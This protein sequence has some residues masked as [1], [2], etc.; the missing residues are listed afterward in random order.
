MSNR[1]N[2]PRLWPKLAS[3]AQS[4]KFGWWSV[5][6]LFAATI[7]LAGFGSAVQFENAD[8]LRNMLNREL[9]ANLLLQGYAEDY[10]VSV[11][12]DRIVIQKSFTARCLIPGTENGV[13]ATELVL[14][15][16]EMSD[17]VRASDLVSQYSGEKLVALEF[18]ANRIWDTRIRTVLNNVHSEM[19]DTRFSTQTQRLAQISKLHVGQLAELSV[20]SY[21]INE[22]CNGA[23]FRFA[24]EPHFWAV[25]LK[26]GNYRNISEGLSRYINLQSNA[27]NGL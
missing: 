17:D 10:Q 18:A 20:K 2:V 9:N 26:A 22:F 25:D 13:R 6:I 16:A 3:K 11:Q 14:M 24:P 15:L 23:K 12:E 5:L 7:S 27:R 21:L 8:D 4:A 1:R 19:F